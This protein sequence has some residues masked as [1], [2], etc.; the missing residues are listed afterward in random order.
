M[1][2]VLI[3]RKIDGAA[4]KAADSKVGNLSAGK[5]QQEQR[6]TTASGAR[7]RLFARHD[8]TVLSPL[9]HRQMT[10][11]TIRSDV[12]A[13]VTSMRDSDRASGR[14]GARILEAF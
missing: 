2:L 9:P 1:S 13:K 14:P 11:V 6:P 12:S 5:R 8:S 3:S 7:F 10:A 4:A